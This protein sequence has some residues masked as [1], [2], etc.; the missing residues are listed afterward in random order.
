MEKSQIF[1]TDLATATTLGIFFLF[2]KR[3]GDRMKISKELQGRWH[4]L[5]YFGIHFQNTAVTCMFL[6]AYLNIYTICILTLIGRAYIHHV[7]YISTLI[8]HSNGHLILHYTNFT[9]LLFV[10]LN[11]HIHQLMYSFV[12]FF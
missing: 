6:I 10:L 4:I 11:V 9:L 5:S 12:N 2:L 7:Q 1:S 8:F 3:D